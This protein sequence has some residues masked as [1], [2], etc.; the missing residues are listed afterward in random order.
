MLPRPV[1]H[2]LDRIARGAHSF[3]VRGC[4]WSRLATTKRVW[5]RQ[6]LEPTR[7]AITRGPR[8]PHGR[9][10][11]KPRSSRSRRARAPILLLAYAYDRW[12]PTFFT[13]YADE[14]TPL[15]LRDGTDGGR[16]PLA[17]RERSVD[18]GALVPF[19]RVRWSQSAL[20]SWRRE[21]SV[22][23]GPSAAGEFDRGAL[24]LGWSVNT[25]RRYGYSISPEDGVTAGAAV[26]LTR[27]GLGG[28]GDA[29]LYRADTRGFLRLGPRHGVLALRA[30]GAASR[31]DAS[32]RRTLR[33]GGHG[34]DGGVLSFEEDGSSLLRGFPADT[35]LGTNVVLG[36]AE[37][38]L[39]LGWVERGIGTWPVFLR[40]V[41]VS[42]FVDAGHAWTGRFTA[43]DAKV[44]WGVEAGADVTAGYALPFTWMVG[45][46]WGRDLSNEVPDNR[47]MYVRIGRGF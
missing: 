23:S 13:Q 10:R 37:Y 30:S 42:G 39:P 33:L 28:D 41:H 46:G 7:S 45:V 8:R 25:A 2:D 31:G 3:L 38:R 9:W 18:V 26:E 12:R 35:F 1:K 22:V 4:P 24:R 34:A 43:A 47:E 36:N 32:V 14:T 11:E 6:W 44:S 21:H 20:A 19:R 17:L 16:Q 27:R 40:A 29:E 15:L 5:A